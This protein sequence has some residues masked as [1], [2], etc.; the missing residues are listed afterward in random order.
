MCTS[1]LQQI[2]VVFFA[3]KR[4]QEFHSA[5]PPNSR[6]YFQG[7][8]TAGVGSSALVMLEM[9]DLRIC[10]WLRTEDMTK[11]HGCR[12][13]TGVVGRLGIHCCLPLASLFSPLFSYIH[14]FLLAAPP[15]ALQLG[16]RGAEGSSTL[17]PSQTHISRGTYTG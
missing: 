14:S 15:L 13:V 11:V 2:I 5:T 8:K 1:A 3:Y 4:R 17:L 16:G 9:K 7:N 6:G 12:G 10:M